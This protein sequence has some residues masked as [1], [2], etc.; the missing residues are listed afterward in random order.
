MVLR[1]RFRQYWKSWLALGLLVA[2]AG[3]F[4]LTTAAAGHRTAAAF[5]EFR[6]RHGYDVIVYSGQPLQ[7]LTR[8]P[9][10]SSATPVPVTVSGG[11]G[12]ASCRN[13]I[14]TD[15]FLVNEVPPGQLS[16]MVTLLSGRMPRQSDPVRCWRPSPSPA[17]TAYASAR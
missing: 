2:V 10:V 9:H 1:A 14:D 5:P 3:G 8:L 4:V 12:C 7:Q 11:V 6:T 15:N 16:R 13:P 17:T